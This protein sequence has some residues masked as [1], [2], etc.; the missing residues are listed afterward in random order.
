MDRRLHL[1]IAFVEALGRA[2]IARAQL[3]LC[4]N[5]FLALLAV[6]ADRFGLPRQDE[7]LEVKARYLTIVSRSRVLKHAWWQEL[8]RIAIK[9]EKLNEAFC[10]AAMGSLYSRGGGTLGDTLRPLAEQVGVAPKVLRMTPAKIEQL[11][12]DYAALTD[13]SFVLAKSISEAIERLDIS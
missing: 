12:S 4:F 13:V 6:E 11:A 3:E 9:A 1:P 10:D 8:H 2:T 5:I 7:P